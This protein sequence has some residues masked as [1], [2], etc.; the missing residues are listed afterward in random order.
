MRGRKNQSSNA[1]AKGK[2]RSIKYKQPSIVSGKS[3]TDILNM[4]IKDFNKLGLSDLRKVVGRLVSAVNKRIRRFMKSGI[5]TPATRSLEK[6]GGMLSTKGKDLNQLRTEYARARDFLNMET[7]SRKGY[8]D[9]QKKTAQTLRDRGVDVTT[10]ELD[11]IFEVYGR[12][13]E[14][15]PSVGVILSSSQ[16]IGE[17]SKLDNTQDVQ[18]RIMQAKERYNELYEE[19]QE[20]FGRDVTLYGVSGFFEI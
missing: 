10:D 16:V 8:E 12:L 9:V 11:D 17:I 3:I 13:K 5:S 4:D 20:Q 2:A 7:S 6:S 1:G 14:I 15:D 19:N 18:T